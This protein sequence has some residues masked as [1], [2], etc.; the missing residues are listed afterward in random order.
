ML[1]SLGAYPAVADSFGPVS[2]GAAVKHASPDV[3]MHQLTDLTAGNSAANAA[4]YGGRS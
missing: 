3:V 1:R 4:L 2:L